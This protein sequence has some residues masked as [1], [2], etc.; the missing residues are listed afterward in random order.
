[1]HLNPLYVMLF[2]VGLVKWQKIIAILASGK[3]MHKHWVK[4]VIHNRRA[5]RALS[6]VVLVVVLLKD[7]DIVSAWLSTERD[8]YE[9]LSIYKR[10]GLDYYPDHK[11]T[12]RYVKERLQSRDVVIVM[13]WMQQFH[14][15]GRIDYW[16]R[17]DQFERTYSKDG[18]RRD[19]YTGVLVIPTLERLLQ[20]ITDNS[21]RRVWI[22]TSSEEVRKLTKITADIVEFLNTL[23]PNVVYLGRDRESK[24]YLLHG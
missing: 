18:H 17:T 6:A 3:G 14:Y 4:A 15:I 13:D 2:A 24:V 8:Y 5:R 16:I 12:G 20:V 1:M 10:V 7:V 22:V 21:N 23:S 11:T 19:L 9:S